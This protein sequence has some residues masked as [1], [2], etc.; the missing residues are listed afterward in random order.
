M[1]LLKMAWQAFLV[2]PLLL[3]SNSLLAQNQMELLY[4]GANPD[5]KPFETTYGFS[6]TGEYDFDNGLFLSGFYNETDFLASGPEVGNVNVESWLETG[7]G[8]AFDHEWGQFYSLITFE[9]ITAE[10]HTYEGFGAH[11]GYRKDWSENWSTVL[12]FGYLD[13][14]F[15]DFQLQAKVNYKISDNFAVTLG[16]RDYD[17]WDYTSYEVGIVYR[18]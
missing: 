7:I 17:D 4:T 12:Q 9:S 13:T 6:I 1:N 8:Y 5:Y 2:V 3:L 10:H 16:L 18:F 11:F 14:E 15:H